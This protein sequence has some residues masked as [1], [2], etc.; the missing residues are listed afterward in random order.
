MADIPLGRANYHRAVAKEARIQLRNRYY[1]PNPAL[2]ETGVALIARPAMRRY[3]QVG[4]GP[5]RGEYSQPGSFANAVF[6][7]SGEKWYRVDVNGATTLLTSGVNPGGGSISMA[8]TGNIGDTPAYM[9]MADGR[10]LWLYIENGYAQGTLSGSPANNDV[11]RIG[12]V[13]YKFTN[14]AL[15]TGN[16]TVGT[17]WLVKLGANDAESFTNLGAAVNADGDAGAQYSTTLHDANPDAQR[18]NTGAS[19][20]AVRAIAIG[21]LGNA[22]TTTETGAVLAWTGATLTGG[23]TPSVTTVETPDNVGI[24]SVGYVGSNVIC[25]PA[26][27]FN[28]NGRFFWIEPGETTIDPIN[29]AT[30]E[31]SPDPINQVVV[32][33][34]QFWL[35]GTSTTEVWY[36]TGNAD[37]PVLRLQ[38]VAFNRGSWEGTAVQVKESMILADSDGGVFQIAG[39]LNRISTPDIEQRIREAI[40]YESSRI[41]Y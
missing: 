20:L 3:I 29:F 21:A 41:L 15:A 36:F 31:S 14:G 16:G 30:A 17:P 8:A 18:I 26:Q 2:T 39:G 22:V 12:S 34:D 19:S 6:V 13:Y 9:F 4:S 38:G 28:I 32:F 5:I 35:P 40:Q 11:V 23:G 1:E 7:V 10:N 37:A 24:I 25:I 33:G 27:G